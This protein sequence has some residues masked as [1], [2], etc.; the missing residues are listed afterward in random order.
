MHQWLLAA[1]AGRKA[2]RS[3]G[4]IKE[5]TVKKRR[6]PKFR[7]RPPGA[8]VIARKAPKDIIVIK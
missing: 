1:F 6:R 3:R 8:K 4:L 2:S 7:P 5:R